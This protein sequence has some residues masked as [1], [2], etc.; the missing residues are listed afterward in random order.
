MTEQQIIDAGNNEGLISWAK[1]AIDLL[2]DYE[3]HIVRNG[4]PSSDLPEAIKDSLAMTPCTIYGLLESI[5]G[6]G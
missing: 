2:K 3:A 4:G 5:D 1:I 6:R